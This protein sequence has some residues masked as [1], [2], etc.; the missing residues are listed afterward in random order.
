M[1]DSSLSR[2]RCLSYLELSLG[3]FLSSLPSSSLL[4]LL[5]FSGQPLFS[6]AFIAALSTPT[7]AI[8]NCTIPL[9]CSRAHHRYSHV[10]KAP[11]IP[12][13][14]ALALYNVF[15]YPLSRPN[16]RCCLYIRTIPLPTLNRF[17][18]LQ[19]VH[20]GSSKRTGLS[21]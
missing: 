15:T 11:A 13:R 8:A 4:L 5:F 12:S 1:H 17:A 18:R 2:P 16:I 20:Q 6:S 10:S 7:P 19:P 14:F 3:V 9:P 21:S